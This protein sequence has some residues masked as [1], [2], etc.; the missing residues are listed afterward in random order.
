MAANRKLPFG[1][2]IKMGEIVVLPDEAEV[3][4]W[5]FSQHSNGS[6]YDTLT[7]EL[8]AQPV[9]YYEGKAWNKNMV[10]RILA[11]ERYLGRKGFPQIITETAYRAVQEALPHRR[12]AKKRSEAA[13]AIQRL[14]VCGVCGAKVKRASYEHG[15]ER[16]N[17]PECKSLSTK[18][19]DKKLE[20]ETLSMLDLL[21]V[22]PYM[23]E[24]AVSEAASTEI[25]AAEKKLED[26][27]NT[28][29][30][31][32]DKARKA[33]MELAA[34]RFEAIGAEGYETLRIRHALSHGEV[35][36]K[37]GIELLR[38]I[39]TAVFIHPDGTVSLKLKNGQII[40]RSQEK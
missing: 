15:K 28:K 11:D 35:S 10:A 20:Q 32:E 3:V 9:P 19:T 29:D 18:A 12:Q 21:R 22:S 13:A 17:C 8:Q 7:K 37:H 23:V 33:A 27:M 5:I 25:E 26:A 36:G 2:G 6:S 24:A 14:A 39:T 38:Q 40:E 34:A 16:W 30:F 1:Y 4:I 31:D